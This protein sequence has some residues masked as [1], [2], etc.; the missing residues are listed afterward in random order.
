MELDAPQLSY[1]PRRFHLDVDLSREDR[2][3]EVDLLR[4]NA[5]PRLLTTQCAACKAWRLRRHGGEQCAEPALPRWVPADVD[6]SPSFVRRPTTSGKA[7]AGTS[8]NATGPDLSPD[9]IWA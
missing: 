2:L 5:A 1:Q 3:W 6:L 8:T 4:G 7:A 9:L